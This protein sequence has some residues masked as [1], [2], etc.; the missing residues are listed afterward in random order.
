[1]VLKPAELSRAFTSRLRSPKLT[2]QLGLLLGLAIGIC[3]GTGYLS[4]AIQHP[5]E[6]FSWPSRPVNL[7][8]ITQ[9]LH[10]ATGLAAIPLLAAKLWSVYPKLFRF[11]PFRSV[12]HAIERLSLIVLVAGAIFQLTTGIL[13]IARWYDPMGFF[14]TV[15]HYWTAWITVG[16]LLVHIG[17]KLPIIRR[18][19]AA[20]PRQ[21]PTTGLTR[22]GLLA[23]VG[24]AVG[25]VTLATVG[26]TFRPLAGISLLAPRDPRVGP[27]GLPVNTSARVAGV[28]VDPKTYTL[29]VRGPARE[30]TLTLDDLTAMAQADAE[31]PITCVEG[32]SATAHWSGVRI[33]DL[34]RAVG[35]DDTSQVTVRSLQEIGFYTS[36]IVA[37][38][39]AKDPL[40]L[41]ALR[42]NGEPLHPDHGFPCRLIAPN[43]PGVMQTKW[44]ASIIV[45]QP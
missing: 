17:V 26:Q 22:R 4:H 3:L 1:M 6:W 37:P 5:P 14:F 28:Q 7:Y 32:W 44:I 39:H 25:V 33:R 31:L 41:L 43:R 38:P 18:A 13:N 20:T 30:L 9:G 15:A 34:V 16:A 21:A 19:L 10:V 35:G 42:I 29:A 27:Q 24:A 23:S 36:S 12:V 8:R 45:E 2:S 40:T 11:P